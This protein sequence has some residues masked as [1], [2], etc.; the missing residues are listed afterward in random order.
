MGVSCVMSV[1]IPRYS[2][3]SN[4]VPGSIHKKC[5]EKLSFLLVQAGRALYRA[6]TVPIQE[7]LLVGKT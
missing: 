2:V 7:T 4:K 3:R 5:N 1:R 6:G